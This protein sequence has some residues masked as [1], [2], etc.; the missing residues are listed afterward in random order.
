MRINRLQIV[1][2]GTLFVATV[3]VGACKRQVAAVTPPPPPPP[4]PAAPS[5]ILTVEPSSI[6]QGESATLRWSSQNATDLNLGNGP[7]N[8]SLATPNAS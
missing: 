5:V 2:L 8:P 3:V 7:A 6:Q 1:G 4:P